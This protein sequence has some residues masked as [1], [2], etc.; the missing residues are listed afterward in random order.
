MPPLTNLDPVQ[1]SR[2]DPHTRDL[3]EN[4]FVG[5]TRYNPLTRE[6][7]PMLA[8]SWTVSDNGLLWTFELRD[9]IQ[10]VR[11][12]ESAQE[13][14]TVRPVAAGDFVYAIQRACDPL[15]PSP[16]TPNLMI[17][18]GCQT[19]ANAFPEVIDDLFIANQIAVRATG[20]TTLEIEILYPSAYFPTLVS[21]PEF[22]PLAREAV[23]DTAIWTGA[24]TILSNGPYALQNSGASGMTLTQ[25]PHWPDTYEGNVEQIEVTFTSETTTSASLISSSRVDMARLESNEISAARAS[26]SDKF[27]SSVGKTLV[28]LGFSYDRALVN[29]PEIRRALALALDRNILVSSLFPDQAEA[30]TQFTPEDVVAAPEFNGL[31]LDVSQA[32]ANYT[33]AGFPSCS[34]VPEKLLVLVPEED[35][36][37]AQLGQ[38]I[39]DQWAANLAC[40]PALFEVRTL[41]RT[42]L[43]ELSHATYDQE[44]VTRS[45]IWMATWSADYPDANNWISDV[46]HCRYG[47][48]K[49]GR[50]CDEADSLLD[51]A[52]VEMDP[53]KRAD[54]YAQAEERFF[55]PNGTFPVIPLYRSVSAWLQQPWLTDV[56]EYGPARYDLWTIDATA[57]GGE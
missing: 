52:A 53:D 20:P 45:H 42:L 8:K 56:N 35:P 57:Q 47:Y 54:L 49:T 11:Y 26:A 17:I 50:E 29:V 21:T 18:R 9:D 36:V 4:L 44:T 31:E 12:D 3:V 24:D 39:V 1:V 32:Q 5:L 16:V 23:S 41:P 10:W 37:W 30:V 2:F 48:I 34:G 27:Q 46:L 15:R 33:T 7:E 40:S 22:R 43:I 55:G 25:N 28:M 51:Q 38:S 6:A 14:V 13:V 19:V